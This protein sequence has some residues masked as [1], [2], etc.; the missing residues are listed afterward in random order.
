M[1]N[2]D[3]IGFRFVTTPITQVI[4]HGRGDY[5]EAQMTGEMFP[6]DIGEMIWDFYR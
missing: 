1:R 5:L 4:V 3:I 6:P 2:Y